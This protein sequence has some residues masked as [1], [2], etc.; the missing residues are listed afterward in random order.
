MRKMLGSAAMVA[1]LWTSAAAF[2]GTYTWNGASGGDWAVPGNWLVGGAAAATAP[3]SADN[4]AFDSASSVTVGGSTALAITQ[5]ANTGSGTVTFACPVQFS[6][7]YY[8]TQNG[9]VKFP[10][11]ATATYP[12]NALRT[13]SS[14]DRTRTLDGDFTFTADW[15]V[16]KVGDK[17]WIIPNGSVVHGQLFTGTEATS[18]RILR[19]EAGGSAYFTVVSNGWNKGDID[20]DGWLEASSEVVMQSNPAGSSTVTR[21]GRSGNVGTVKAPRIVKTG[22]SIL[23]SLIPNLIV[24]AGGYGSIEQDYYLR[25]DVNTTITVTDNCNFLGVYRSANTADWGVYINNIN[26]TIN[27]QEGK[28]A[29]YGAGILASGGVIRKTGA[30]TLVMSDTFNNQSGYKKTYTGGTRVDEG[31]LRLAAT[32]QLGTG[33]VTVSEGARFEIAGGVTVSNQVDGPGTLY[34]E[35]GATLAM[36]NGPWTV[37]AVEVAPNATVTVKMPSG[38]SAPFAFLT[39]VDAADAARFA[40]AGHTLSLVGGVLVLKGDTTGAYVWA[41]ASGGDWATPGNWRVD[42]AVPATAPGSGDTI[43]FENDTALTVGGT[44]ALT[45][46]KIVTY[47]GAEVTF[48]CPVQFAGTYLVQN[49]VVPPTFAGGATATYPDASLSALAGPSRVLSGDLTFTQNWTIPQQPNG[50]PFVVAD[51]STVTG[52]NL[53]GTTNAPLSLVVNEGAVA[54]FD[55]IAIA[56]KLDFK[57]AGGRLVANGDI[58]VGSN[59]TPR[60]FGSSSGNIGTV[61]ANGIYKNVSGHGQIDVYVTNFVVGAG[62]FG[63]KRKDYSFKMFADARLTAKDDLTIYEPARTDSGAPKDDD[64]G[65]NFNSHTFTVDTGNHTVTFDSFTSPNAGK[66]VKEGVGEMVMQNRQKK[67]S[68]GTV[69]KAGTLTVTVSGGQGYGPLTVDGGATL[70]YTVVV[71]HPY[72]LTLGAGSILKP[73]QNAYFDVSGGS[74]NLPAEGTVAVDMTGFTFVN[75]VPIPIISGAAAGDEAK[76]TA[77]LPAGVSGAFSVSD[78]VLNFTPTAGGSA[79]ADLF[80]HPTGESVWSD[81]VAAWTNA[82]GEQVAFTPYAKVTVADA[83]T[84]S[85]PADVEASDV[86]IA[87]D[88]AV[89]L[90]GAGKL[91]GAGSIVKTGS[92]TFTFN[93]TGGLDA[94]PLLV[95]NGVFRMGADLS[96]PLGGTADAAPIVV[97]DGATLDVNFTNSDPANAARSAVTRE[98]LVRVSGEGADGRGAIVNDTSNTYY[99]FSDIVLDGDATLGGSKRFDVRGVSGYVRSTGSIIGPGKTLTVKNTSNFGIVNATVDL[100]AIVVTNGAKL[101]V[102]G[103][104]TKWKIDEGIRMYGGGISSYQNFIYPA[105]LAI[106]VESGANT[107]TMDGGGVTTN[108]SAIMVA[109]G[110]TLTQTAGDIIY[111]GPVN[112]TIGMTGGNMYLGSAPMA[113]L[114]L[115]GSKSSGTVMLRGSGT[116]SG[117]NVT[118]A[119]FGISD[120]ANASVTATFLDSTFDVINLYL[121]WGSPFVKGCVVSIGEGTTL[122]TSKIAIGDSGTNVYDNVK[123]VLSVD[124][125]TIHHTNTLFYIGYASPRAEFVL[126]DGTVTV[127]KA[128]I[129]LHANAAT[130]FAY[131]GGHSTSVFRQ[132]GGTF[133]YGGA[134]F[135]SNEFEDNTEDGFIV[136]KGGTFNATANWSIPY[137]MPLSF[138]DGAEGC[139]TLNQADGTTVTWTTA[140][141]GDADVTLNGAATL[142]GTNEI[143][144]AVG[145][146]WT[147]GDGF[148]AGLEGAAS[149][150]GGLDLGEGATATV[151]I[152]TNR[153]A[154]FTARDGGDE[155]GKAGCITS[156]FNRVFG[157]TTRGTITHDETFLL[158]KPAAANRPFGNR[159]HQVAYAVGQ[160]Y[161][162]PEK[163]GKWYFKGYSDDY[164]LL[165]I[166]GETV[167]SSVGGTRCATRYGTNDLATGWHTFRQVS[168]DFG[169]DF[170]GVPTMA[171]NTDGSTTYTPFSVHTVKMRPAADR[172]AGNNA[173]TVR[174]SH[175]KGTA[176]EVGNGDLANAGGTLWKGD[177][178]WDFRCITNNLQMLDWKGNNDPTF[179]NGN[180]INRFEGWFLVTE[181]NADKA[182][183]F[184]GQYDDNVGLWIDGVDSKLTGRPGNNTESYTVTLARGWHSFTIQIAD[185]AGDAGPWSTAKP[186]LSYQVADGPQVQFSEA[187]LQLSVCPDGYVQGGVTLASGATLANGAAENAAV[188]YGDVAAT[189][190]GATLAGKFKFAGGTLAFQNVAPNTADLANVLAFENP[191]ADM[192]ADVDAITVD[193]ADKPTRGRIPVCPLYGLT[194]E[195]A[196]AKISVTVAGEPAEHIACTVENGTITLRNTSGTVLFFR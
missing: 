101:R 43:L 131:L 169:G 85:L 108:N 190:T 110:A 29:T 81:A 102:E 26:L 182:W 64:W 178:P 37:G 170:G 179:L 159:N 86:S 48:S 135:A 50:Y 84:I 17:P 15:T 127:D 77:L 158:T 164:I 25:I 193:Y 63:M 75:G 60:N 171:Y 104:S 34:I 7:T 162:E 36:G 6:G 156:R 61:E 134:G 120:L 21:F 24:G 176:A 91:G 98:K 73:A 175:Y 57:L 47:S 16:N 30:G 18:N 106:R 105:N 92:G 80:W 140:L 33:A 20:I 62:G 74:L 145:G 165:E 143:Q 187:T 41:G 68:G 66:L 194:E 32:G 55:S 141:Y 142:V 83:A 128:Q 124:G 96:G 42:G 78:G 146:K 93:A 39:G 79:A 14:T 103:N 115:A 184:R 183:T 76:F 154:V 151:N 180:T 116:Y 38:M 95:S 147:V 111:N 153:S 3:T 5:I 109:P 181:E 22:R 31:T 163:A 113:G 157:G 133:N 100:K 189:G 4:I 71:G 160:F 19:V 119:N 99:T 148:T 117:A 173:N 82:A 152:A 56:G 58:T 52:K 168:V 28:T 136:F 195:A 11:G 122:T 69:V 12:D 123:S 45:V 196:K 149:L 174:W 13:A 46:M 35:N 59:G 97:A 107:I 88:G 139:W 44:G 185:Y 23:S 191:A 54:T 87:A 89:T 125:G 192:L 65:L 72:P 137:F 2:A 144:G 155:F 53:A 27:V 166:D 177:F 129:L 8:V 90:N 130:N 114:T 118:C 10:G 126:N 1:V 186:T 132:N 70:A 172:G 138:K 112:G 40:L 67:H 94:Q 9:P 161:V 188:I 49:V 150:L 51:G 167:L 121:G